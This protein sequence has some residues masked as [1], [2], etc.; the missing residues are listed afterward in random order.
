MEK[1]VKKVTDERGRIVIS[2]G[3]GKT[4]AERLGATTEEVKE[5]IKNLK[6]K[7]KGPPEKK[8]PS[9]IRTI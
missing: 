9:R 5:N 3:A 7:D 1:I 4:L 2:G 8:G 6:E